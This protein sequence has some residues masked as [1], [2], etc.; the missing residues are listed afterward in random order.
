MNTKVD[1]TTSTT[2]T[3]LGFGGFGKSALATGL[4]HQ[5]EIQR[6]FLDGV[7]WIKLGPKPPDTTMMLHKIY[8]QLTNESLH[9]ISQQT[10]ISIEDQL[11]G[12]VFN[13]LKR[14]LVII[15]NVWSA[16]DALIYVT[17]LSSCKIVLTTRKNDISVHIP[18]KKTIKIEEMSMEESKILLTFGAVDPQRLKFL[19]SGILENLAQDLHKWPLLLNLARIQLHSQIKLQTPLEQAVLKVH[20]VL[21]D[22][23]LTAFDKTTISKDNAVKA[24]VNATLALL[25]EKELSNLKILVLYAG[26]GITV[27][28]SSLRFYWRDSDVDNNLEKLSS[29]GLVT[30]GRMS[31]PPSICTLSCVEMHAVITQYLMDSMDYGTYKQIYENMGISA[32]KLMD[33]S[34]SPEMLDDLFFGLENK[35]DFEALESDEKKMMIFQSQLVTGS[36]DN[37]GIPISI[38]RVIILTKAILQG[39]S[40]TL[41]L[42][43]KQFKN[44]PQI[45]SL[46]TKFKNENT[47]QSEKAYKHFRKAYKKIKSFLKLDNYNGTMNAIKE[48]I[49]DLPIQSLANNFSTLVEELKKNCKEDNASVSFIEENLPIDHKDAGDYLL[50]EWMSG[51]ELQ[52][53]LRFALNKKTVTMEEQFDIIMDNCLSY[54]NWFHKSL[55][56]GNPKL[57]H[58]LKSFNPEDKDVKAS[59]DALAE[60][61]SNMFKRDPALKT[62]MAKFFD[63]CEHLPIRDF[64]LAMLR[65]YAQTTPSTLP[66]VN[67]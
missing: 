20:K 62:H 23:G 17:I 48:Y 51:F 41:E 39:V 59:F 29:C 33:W 31:L 14:L 60:A 13:N 55:T 65:R 8:N 34:S 28:K 22:E 61:F 50:T 25:T 64:V 2:V 27:P 66:S 6:Y 3:L 24:C 4:C 1:E 32:V 5:P 9:Q 21:Y 35:V 12:Y 54:L 45:L 19:K 16:E 11:L 58:K 10:N 47:M 52:M 26:T 7:L 43:L 53:K 46:L 44:H 49:Q 38:Q 15:D 57:L 67:Y 18:T 36:M 63:I 42:F 56:K 40:E 30:I 37:L